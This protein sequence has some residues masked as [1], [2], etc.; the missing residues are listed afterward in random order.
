MTNEKTLKGNKFADCT[1]EELHNYWNE[2]KDF[3]ENGW[4]S[5]DTLLGK[6]RDIYCKEFPAGI[7]IM[8]QDLMRAICCKVFDS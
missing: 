7:V 4:I 6:M 1:I 8:E 3:Y 5:S 2:M